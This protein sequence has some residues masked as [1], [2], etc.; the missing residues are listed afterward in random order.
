MPMDENFTLLE[1]ND[2][3]V[4]D[5]MNYPLL[6]PPQHCSDFVRQFARSYHVEPRLPQG[7]KS[8]FLN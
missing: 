8:M 5:S 3:L 6:T 4:I 7:L 2:V 1:Q